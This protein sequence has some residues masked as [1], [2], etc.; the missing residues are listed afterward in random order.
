MKI[1]FKIIAASFLLF[2]IGCDKG[3]TNQ[4]DAL[5]ADEQLIEAIRASLNKVTIPEAQLP[6]TSKN[7]IGDDY[8]DELTLDAMLAPELGYEVFMGGK[9]DHVG[10]RSELYFNLEGRKLKSG[11]GDKGGKGRGFDDKDSWKCF[12][13][14]YPV[15]FIMPDESSITVES[16]AG[17]DAL[18]AWYEVNPGY[19]AKPQLQYPVQIQFEDA[20]AVTINNEV[21]MRNAYRRCDNEDRRG[22][23]EDRD[24]RNGRDRSCFDLV[25][26][27]SFT[28][29][30]GSTITVET[31]ENYM[32]LRTWYADHPDAAGHPAL[33]YP[34]E[35]VYETDAGD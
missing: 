3:V 7:V 19:E 21:E 4:G 31:D 6:E 18:K 8:A 20:A 16:E 1:L 5:S 29:P 15:T 25:L 34:V 12:E 24:G 9:V 10:K 32:L 13:L 26:P 17:F 28:M 11:N 2:M 30:D 22:G 23:H 27:A 33:Q 35:I 14:I